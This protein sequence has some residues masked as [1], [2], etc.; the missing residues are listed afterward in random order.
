MKFISLKRK[1]VISVASAF[2]LA[3][4]LAG[5]SSDPAPTPV[6]NAPETSSTK[7]V[8]SEKMLSKPTDNNLKSITWLTSYDK[9]LS[10]AKEDNKPVMIDFYADWCSACKY[11]DKNIYTAPDVIKES[12]GFINLKIN[13]DKDTDIASRYKVY[14]LPT[15]IFLDGNGK[16]LWRLE[17]APTDTPY[18]I[19]T[20]QKAQN[21][22][23]SGA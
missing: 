6:A 17:G 11:L 20:M 5:C 12:K 19:E 1:T 2:I 10:T 4:V 9:A 23:T 7:N 8:S 3:V 21:K 13:T 16:V 18:F 15:L 14:A 22:F